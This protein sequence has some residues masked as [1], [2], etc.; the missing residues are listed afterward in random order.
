MRP[1]AVSRR[2]GKG[3]WPADSAQRQSVTALLAWF[4]GSMLL[5]SIKVWGRM[6]GQM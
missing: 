3:R 5:L 1:S 6:F 4:A 2:K